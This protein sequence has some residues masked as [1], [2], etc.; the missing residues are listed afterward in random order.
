MFEL[1]VRLQ[2]KKNY[3]IMSIVVQLLVLRTKSFMI[4]PF[5]FRLVWVY[6]KKR[7]RKNSQKRCVTTDLIWFICKMG[8][9]VKIIEWTA[10]IYT[11]S[12][13]VIIIHIASEMLILPVFQ[14]YYFQYF[15]LLLS[16]RSSLSHIVATM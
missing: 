6:A 14:F 4:L 5:R 8:L 15:F 1:C 11:F 10:K 9:N 2:L 12:N 13:D 7:R 16:C 3:F